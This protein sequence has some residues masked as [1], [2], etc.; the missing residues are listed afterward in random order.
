MPILLLNA[1]RSAQYAVGGRRV[2]TVR[3][4]TTAPAANAAAGTLSRR[5]PTETSRRRTR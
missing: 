5:P 3:E 2:I 1:A 4:S